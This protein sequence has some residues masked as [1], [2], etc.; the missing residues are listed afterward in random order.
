MSGWSSASSAGET[1]D[2]EEKEEVT[3]EVKGLAEK[4]KEVVMGKPKDQGKVSQ[5]LLEFECVIF[6][7]KDFRKLRCFIKTREGRPSG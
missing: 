6:I 1:T 4:L 3:S 2:E 5:H 7:A